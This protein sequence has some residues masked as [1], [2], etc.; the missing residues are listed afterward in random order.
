MSSFRYRVKRP[1]YRRITTVLDRYFFA[2]VTRDMVYPVLYIALCIFLKRTVLGKFTAGPRTNT[3]RELLRFW[4]TDKLISN[5][6][7][8]ETVCSCSLI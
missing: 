1:V 3:A 2:K 7:E 6:R 4:F 8:L 5:S